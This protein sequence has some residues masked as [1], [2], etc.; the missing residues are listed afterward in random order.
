MDQRVEKSVG[1]V[2]LVFY[3]RGPFNNCFDS[4]R[5][6]VCDHGGLIVL[7]FSGTLWYILVVALALCMAICGYLR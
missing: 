2:P 3:P 6:S 1:T 5:G 7:H 4:L